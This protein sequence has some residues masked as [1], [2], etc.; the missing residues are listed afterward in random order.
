[1]RLIHGGDFQP[2]PGQPHPVASFALADQQDFL[3]RGKTRLLGHQKSIG[4]GPIGK[5]CFAMRV[6]RNDSSKTRLLLLAQ[7]THQ[8]GEG[9]PL[10]HDGKNHHRGRDHYQCIAFHARRQGQ[11]QGDTDTTV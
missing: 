1:M 11:H 6:S 4:L 9:Q 8:R 7:T 10:H 5:A 2:L 3:S